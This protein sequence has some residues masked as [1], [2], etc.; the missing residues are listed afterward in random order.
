MQITHEG[1][2]DEGVFLFAVKKRLIGNA[3]KKRDGRIHFHGQLHAH[4]HADGIGFAAG[5]PEE[6]RR[7]RFDAFGQIHLKLMFPFDALPYLGN[8]VQIVDCAAD[9]FLFLNKLP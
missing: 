9:D 1:F 8:H 5:V 3:I 4:G 6:K 2:G 7:G